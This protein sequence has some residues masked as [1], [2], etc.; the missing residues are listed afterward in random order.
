MGR[1]ILQF[2][3]RQ[4]SNNLGVNTS[5]I[6]EIFDTSTHTT[7]AAG[8]PTTTY[9]VNEIGGFSVGDTFYVGADSTPKTITV[10][11]GPDGTGFGIGSFGVGA[12]DAAIYALGAAIILK[13]RA[14]DPGVDAYAAIFLDPDFATDISSNFPWTGDINNEWVFFI[15]PGEYGVRYSRPVATTLRA[16]HSVEFKEVSEFRP[17]TG[18]SSLSGGLYEAINRLPGA[19]GTALLD[20]GILVYTPNPGV[21]VGPGIQLNPTTRLIGKGP[22]HTT[23][24]LADD[25]SANL[26]VDSAVLDLGIQDDIEISNLTIDG[27]LANAANQAQDDYDG[28]RGSGSNEDVVLRNVRITGVRHGV[29]F[30][31]SNIDSNRMILDNVFVE[32]VAGRGIWLRRVKKAR[33]TNCKVITCADAGIEINKAAAGTSDDVI[34][35][36]CLVNRATAPSYI[37][38]GGSE[39]GALIH[40]ASLNNAI[41]NNCILWNNSAATNNPGLRADL[42]VNRL[43]FSDNLVGLA[44]QWGIGLAV[45]SIFEGN[46]IYRP[47]THGMNLSGV[48]SWESILIRNNLFIDMDEANVGPTEV[49]CLHIDMDASS[50]SAT[51]LNKLSIIGNVLRD[52]RGRTD[53]GMSLETLH[54]DGSTIQ[55]LIVTDNDFADAALGL[56]KWGADPSVV[57][58]RVRNNLSPDAYSGLAVLVAGTLAVQNTRWPTVSAGLVTP[59]FQVSRQGIGATGAAAMGLLT[60]T[61]DGTDTMT[62]TAA[63]LLDATAAVAADVSEVF[64]EFVG[65]AT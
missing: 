12:G 21:G 49:Y 19:G 48:T 23:I 29:N 60:A 40:L 24:R 46:T 43:L 51:T 58:Y 34:L 42:S 31:G 47:A 22:Q 11:N 28:I 10:I 9:N 41:I 16:D 65:S 32:D 59:R 35:T 57:N 55:Q 62:I 8:T 3:E 53:Y 1:V 63:Q 37:L 5:P 20:H 44:G 13:E 45:E 61:Y 39:T 33:L 54:A 50:P 38:D 36:G 52:T 6:L 30:G 56:I 14:A 27:N 7:S 17:V 2:T 15:K 25:V 18:T 4:A 64:W 26:A